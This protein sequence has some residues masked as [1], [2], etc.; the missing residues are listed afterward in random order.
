MVSLVFCPADFMRFFIFLF[1][2]R[3]CAFLFDIFVFSG[4]CVLVFSVL[5]L[6]G[7]VW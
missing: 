4:C 1:E 6:S 3:W 2:W 5:V 7:L